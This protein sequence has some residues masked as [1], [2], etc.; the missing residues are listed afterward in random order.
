[1]HLPVLAT[2]RDIFAGHKGVRSQAIPRL[3][4]VGAGRIVVEHPARMLGTPG[5]VNEAAD[6]LVLAVPEPADAAVLAVFMPELRIDVRLL[7]EWSN[8]F[9]TVIDR[10]RRKV[11]GAGRGAAGCA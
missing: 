7:V 8:E 3:V 1:M 4:I 5:L 10:S 11:L 2:D 6:L 9:I